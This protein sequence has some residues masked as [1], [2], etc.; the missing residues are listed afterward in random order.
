MAQGK[1]RYNDYDDFA[2]SY[3]RNNETNPYNALYERPAILSLAGA[4]GGLRVLDAG[5]GAGVHAADLIRRGAIVTG[6]DRSA[7]LLDIA[8]QRLGPAVPLHRADLGEPLP[9]QDNTFD[10]VLSALVMHYLAEWE[11][12]LGEFRRVLRPRGRLVLSTHHPVMDMRISGSDDYFGTY[13]YTEDWQRD[14]RTMRM[15][16]WHR[17]LRAMVTAFK[18]SGFT[19]DDIVEPDPDPE[20]AHSDPQCYR[21]LTRSPQF[22]FFAL[23][24]H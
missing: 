7:G 15:R 20:L 17:P 18:A 24:A 2:Q 14:G 8:R 23:T 22:I 19:I 5:C 16:F 10:L 4:V 1:V 13:T 6:I 21:H 3:A 9:F 11:P 12:V